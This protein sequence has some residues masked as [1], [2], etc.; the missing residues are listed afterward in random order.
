MSVVLHYREYGEPDPA[1]PSL[2][3]LH[4]LFGSGINWHG[5]ARRL[6]PDWHLVVPD[7]R[8]HGRSPHSEEMDYPA[9]AGDVLALMDRLGLGRFMPVGHSM[10]GKVAMT[11]ALRWGERVAALVVADMAPVRYAHD[12]SAVFAAFHAVPLARISRRAEADAYMARH[13]SDPAVRQYLLQNLVQ[14]RD[15][16]HWR[17]NLPVL[18]RS[19]GVI[20]D[21]SLSCTPPWTGPALFLRGGL[22][23]YIL[24]EHE[25]RIRACFP[26]ARIETLPGVGHWVYA[27]DPEGFV[28]RLRGFLDE[29]LMP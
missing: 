28:S 1:R 9:M 23:D 16:W 6:E 13:V 8:N 24:P 14:D 22:S 4:G 25:P 15:G 5:I 11:L 21:W 29:A 18:E 10:G 20:G 2:C 19:I 3:L 27:E 12:F 7:L 17:L 26:Q